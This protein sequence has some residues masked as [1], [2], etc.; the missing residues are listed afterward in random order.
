MWNGIFCK[1]N[2]SIGVQK[3]S[4]YLKVHICNYVT[5]DRCLH[6]VFKRYSD[7]VQNERKGI[8]LVFWLQL[9]YF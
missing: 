9:V 1:Q 6:I 2:T 4:K 7:P 8:E 5:F 3:R